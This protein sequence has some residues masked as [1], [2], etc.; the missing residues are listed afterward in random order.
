MKERGVREASRVTKKEQHLPQGNQL[1]VSWL[2]E[3]EAHFGTYWNKVPVG[4]SVE[5]MCL[6]EADV[7]L[8]GECVMG[9]VTVR[10]MAV[11]VARAW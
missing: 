2:P 8:H 10:T 1:R 4:T 3:K 5:L 9:L 11:F 7:P 6:E